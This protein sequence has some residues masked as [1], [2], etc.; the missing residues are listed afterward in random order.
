LDDENI[1]LGDHILEEFD[2]YMK[3]GFEIHHKEKKENQKVE[4]L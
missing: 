3:E 4:L 1:E 2:A